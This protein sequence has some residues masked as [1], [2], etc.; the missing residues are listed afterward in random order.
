MSHL[1]S[2]NIIER[3]RYLLSDTIIYGGA[4]AISKAFVLITLPFVAR[5]FTVTEFGTLDFMLAMANLLAVGIIFGQDSAVARYFYEF[6]CLHDRSQLISHSLA[7]HLVVI[8]VILPLLWLLFNSLNWDN[9]SIF[10]AQTNSL[11]GI[12][13]IQIPFLVINNFS[14]GILKWTFQRSKYLWLTIGSTSLYSVST[15]IGV[16]FFD[17]N[18]ESILLA[19]LGVNFLFS[20]FGLYFI[21]KWL[22]F[23][24]PWGH[25]KQVLLFAAPY[26]VICLFGAFMP[27]VERSLIVIFL[28]LEQLGIYALGA[29]I[30][31]II[32]LVTGAFQTAWGPFSLAIH[33]NN[34]AI[35]T[36]NLVLKVFSICINI[37]VLTLSLIAPLLISELVSDRYSGAEFIV[38]PLCYGL[39]IQA[40]GWITEIGIMISKKSY[41]NIYGYI[42]FFGASLFGIILLTPV[43]GLIGIAG[44]VLISHI[45]K[46]IFLTALAQRAYYLSWDY[47]SVVMIF[48][49][50]LFFY[51]VFRFFF[52]DVGFYYR[53]A[54]TA[55]G[56]ISQCILG[57][58]CVLN[59][60]DRTALL[61][62][63]MRKL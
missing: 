33:N 46:S 63:A 6:D 11:F 49:Y 43:Y 51:F 42:I 27:I 36:Y 25:M 37:V 13:L 40:T 48:S 15:A 1:G 4:S 59:K 26:G 35:E 5:S 39:A 54:A 20:I 57:W 3:F 58:F 7:Y 14:Q 29:K 47:F 16:V 50:T 52:I 21:R 32:S 30:A 41:L 10:P 31:I 38:F 12:V 28:S 34:D 2:L 60:N 44:A 17:W 45:I 8:S 24:R 23:P 61:R 53:T 55:F 18:I 56:I 62:I 9:W 22:I 19:G